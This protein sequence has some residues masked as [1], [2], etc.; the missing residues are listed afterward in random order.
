MSGFDKVFSAKN[1][2]NQGGLYLVTLEMYCVRFLWCTHTALTND[3]MIKQYRMMEFPTN[4]KYQNRHIFF[5]G[6]SYQGQRVLIVWVLAWVWPEGSLLI[7]CLKPVGDKWNKMKLAVKPKDMLAIVQPH[8]NLWYRF[9]SDI[10]TLGIARMNLATSQRYVQLF[11]RTLTLLALPSA[12][13]CIA[14]TVPVSHQA[15]GA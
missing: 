6:I 14:L 11:I 9:A 3:K 8:P 12:P 15:L 10:Y 13:G 4:Y 7:A 2:I 5:C 1:M